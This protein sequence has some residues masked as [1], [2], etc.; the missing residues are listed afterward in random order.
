MM[1]NVIS[2]RAQD[3]GVV[4]SAEETA[5]TKQRKEQPDVLGVAVADEPLSRKVGGAPALPPSVAQSPL[6]G[7]LAACFSFC[8]SLKE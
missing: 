4:F 7:G 6:Q 8:S 5:L 1:R 2:C 3:G